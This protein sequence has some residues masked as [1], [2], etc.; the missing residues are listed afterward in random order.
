[1]SEQRT[2][3]CGGC[4]VCAGRIPGDDLTCTSPIVVDEHGNDITILDQ[5]RDE[6]AQL[7][8][9]ESERPA[10][11]GVQHTPA[12]WIHRWN[13]ATAAERLK[14]VEQILD[15]GAVASRCWMGDHVA[16]LDW[17]RRAGTRV[18]ALHP[19]VGELAT[20]HAESGLLC[21]ECICPA[22][23][24]TRRA[25]DGDQGEPEGAIQALR[26]AA[27]SEAD[28]HG[29]WPLTFHGGTEGA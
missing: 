29:R 12:E 25:L 8:A 19:T 3:P 9:G 4:H 11:E 14:R 5:L 21:P 18:R 13:R 10:P 26:R 1:M 6:V 7:R 23:C 22:P 28:R 20:Q 2:R 27:R 16:E 17:L 24:P 15:D